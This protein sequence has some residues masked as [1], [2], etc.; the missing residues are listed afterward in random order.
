LEVASHFQYFSITLNDIKGELIDIKVGIDAQIT[1]NWRM[2]VAYNYYKVDVD[3]AQKSDSKDTKI[4]DY[5]I[6][7]SF[8]GPMLSVS[9]TF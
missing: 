2:S 1:A 7:Y 5:N 4:A 6:D 8:I 3:I 9:Y